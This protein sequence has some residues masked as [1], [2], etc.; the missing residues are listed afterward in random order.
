[1][2]PKLLTTSL[3]MVLVIL[4]SFSCATCTPAQELADK[5]IGRGLFS[6]PASNVSGRLEALPFLAMVLS[7]NRAC[8]KRSM[9]SAVSVRAI[10]PMSRTGALLN[11]DF[12]SAGQLIEVRD[13]RLLVD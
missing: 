3:S 2:P 6:Q 7:D 13:S 10:E 4:V 5:G 1:M 8:A 12:S 9:R 11:K